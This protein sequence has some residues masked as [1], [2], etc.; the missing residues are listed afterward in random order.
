MEKVM[1]VLPAPSRPATSARRV[2]S[3]LR[4]LPRLGLA[5]LAVGGAAFLAGC[6]TAGEAEPGEI[7]R[8][9]AVRAVPI[10][11]EEI[12]RPIVATGVVAAKDEVA[13]SF[14]I[15]GV[16]ARVAVDGGARVSAGQMLAELDLR[17][18][19]AQVS[20][21]RSA[22][23]KAERDLERARRL[24]AD[25]VVTLSIRQDTETGAEVAR[26]DLEAA[27]VNREFAV[28]TAPA[29]G[30]I[31]RRT[32]EPGETVPPGAPILLFGSD[33]RGRVLR[34]GLSDRDLVRVARGDPA[35]VR[36]EALPGREITGQ[37]ADISAAAQMGTG[38]YG[39]EIALEG[40]GELA[41]GFVGTAE[42]IPQGRTS[43]ARVPIEAIIEADGDRGV[44]F[45]LSA[46]GG[47]AERREVT[48][49]FIDG[50]DVAVSG[51]L[52]GAVSVITDGAPY[53]EDGAPVT[54]LP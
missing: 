8:P 45:T 46:D 4:T 22:A 13:L 7:D 51:G 28:I 52:E 9:T 26:A 50:T 48:I 29:A 6:G 24:Y 34:V 31:L 14:K 1:N 10:V 38:T 47:H 40:G 16:V 35:V 33:A 5:G 25:S 20:R 36:F 15:G 37:V 2:E 43:A 32:A 49:A 3:R 17:E 12:A 21:A 39:V 27:L 30:V 54:V 23:D 53:L 18:I 44:V 11:Q 42:I 41:N 19:D